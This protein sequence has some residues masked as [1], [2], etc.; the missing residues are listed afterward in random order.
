MSHLLKGIKSIMRMSENKKTNVQKDTDLHQQVE[1]L[2]ERMKAM[3]N[4]LDNG[5]EILTVEEAAKFMGIA[6]SSLYKM[7]SDQL[8]PFYRPNGKMIYFEKSEILAWIRRNRQSSKTEIQ[9]AAIMHEQK[10]GM[11]SAQTGR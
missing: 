2:K 11:R 9:E 6:R 8:I 7:T 3:E 4:I 1:E 10:L 5:K